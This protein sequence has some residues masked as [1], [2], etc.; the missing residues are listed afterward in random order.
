MQ[1]APPGHSCARVGRRPRSLVP[2]LVAGGRAD[3][4]LL[5]P[6]PAWYRLVP[7]VQYVVK[8]KAAADKLL[9]QY[10]FTQLAK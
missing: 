8:D 2:V 6:G 7:P 4:A 5:S 3:L 10:V 1:T 9:K